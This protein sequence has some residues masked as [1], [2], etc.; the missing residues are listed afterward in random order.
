V[1]LAVTLEIVSHSHNLPGMR[2]AELGAVAGLFG[3]SA[4]YLALFF[5]LGQGTPGMH[6]ARIAL[7]TFDG[8]LPSRRMRLQ[9]LASLVLS[10]LPVGVGVL[11]SL[12]DEDHLSWHD[13]LSG[14][15]LR[16]Y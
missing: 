15:Y 11:W 2:G 8:D 12:F 10:V 13:R 16:T 4:L 9:R 3:M 7:S 1:F 14:T 6:Y 5:G